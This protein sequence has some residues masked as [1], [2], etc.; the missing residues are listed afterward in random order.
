ME[1]LD[2]TGYRLD[3]DERFEGELDTGR[4]FPHFLPH[5]STLEQSRAR[6]ETGDGLRLIVDGDSELWAPHLGDGSRVAH[7][8]TGHFSGPIGSAVGQH[9]FR[10]DLRVRT[11]AP[12]LALWH[13]THGVVE[14]RAK[15]IADPDVMVAF[16]PMG[17]E[18]DP[19]DSGE[20]CVFEIFG[21]ELDDTGGRGRY[22]G[23][24]GDGRGCL[25]RR[26]FRRS[27]PGVFVIRLAGIGRSWCRTGF[28]CDGRLA[29][30]GSSR[31][32]AVT[33]RG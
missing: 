15:A 30:F 31:N 14:V 1:T 10:D 27:G 26:G 21:N 19:R 3:V 12:E 24:L 4:W 18:R 33:G 16:W 23:L 9:R 25:I 11:A 5:W 13:L 2:L 22:R 17:V 29:A 20:L 6:F 28:G 32:A 7:L 8:Q